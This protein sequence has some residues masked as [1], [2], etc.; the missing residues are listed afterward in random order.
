MSTKAQTM[1][2][3]R[4]E[5]CV[6]RAHAHRFPR[7]RGLRPPHM[8][9]HLLAHRCQSPRQAAE[10]PHPH[11][12]AHCR[13]AQG[14]HSKRDREAFRGVG[15]A[16]E[17]TSQCTRPTVT[18][19]AGQPDDHHKLCPVFCSAKPHT[20]PSWVQARW[21]CEH[22]LSTLHA[23][24]PAEWAVFGRPVDPAAFPDYLSKIARPMDL[25]AVR[26]ERAQCAVRAWVHAHL[27]GTS[28][29]TDGWPASVVSPSSLVFV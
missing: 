21:A 6:P 13:A 16:L 14:K 23:K 29:C 1:A 24:H 17:C 4:T 15:S 7:S 8:P 25:G 28:A 27:Q 18:H 19:L 9:A 5:G 2:V 22:I 3:G 26:C 10:A 12:A 11:Q 20:L